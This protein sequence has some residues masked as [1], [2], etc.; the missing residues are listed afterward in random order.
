MSSEKYHRQSI[1]LKDYDY[2]QPGAYFIIIC[3]QNRKCLFGEINENELNKIREYIINN[4][5]KWELDIEDLLNEG[6][7][8]N[9]PYKNVTEYFFDNILK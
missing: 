6:Q 2:S 3:T 4:P 5:S 8:M 7:L 1:R 9:Y